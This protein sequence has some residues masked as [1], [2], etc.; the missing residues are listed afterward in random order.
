MTV[1]RKRAPYVVFAL[2]VAAFLPA[3]RNG[4]VSWDDRIILIQNPY[5]RGLGWQNIK[6]MFSNFTTGK[7]QP[8]SWLSLASITA[9]GE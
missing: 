2:T 5:F 1:D 4:F 7:Y 8:L 6:W 3:L 9:C